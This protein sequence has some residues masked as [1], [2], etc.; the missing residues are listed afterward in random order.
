MSH[1][2]LIANRGEIAVR[3]IRAAKEL[4]IET[5]SVYSK[6]DEEALHVKIADHAICVGG[7]KSSDSYLNMNHILSAAISTGCDAIHPGLWIFYQ[8]MQLLLRWLKVGIIFIGPKAETIRLIG[9]KSSAKT[10]CKRRRVSISLM[11]SE[12]VIDNLMRPSKTSKKLD[13]LS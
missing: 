4:G 5:V 9:D 12:G 6:A 7:P 1:K 8:K 13:F 3:I 10:N 11:G 2:I